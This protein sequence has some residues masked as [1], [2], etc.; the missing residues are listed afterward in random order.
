MVINDP[1]EAVA[2]INECKEHLKRQNKS[3]INF[4]AKQVELLKKF[5]ELNGFFDGAGLSRSNIYYKI[6]L[7]KF[8]LK[9]PVSKISTLP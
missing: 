1:K 4:V 8:L 7:F 2:I 6:R 9:C 3:I 5:K